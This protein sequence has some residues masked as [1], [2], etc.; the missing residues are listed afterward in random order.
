[1]FQ[2]S[3]KSVILRR[4]S[5]EYIGGAARVSFRFRFL[6]A[7]CDFFRAQAAGTWIGRRFCSRLKE[8]PKLNPE[9]SGLGF[10]GDKA[11]SF[12]PHR[13]PEALFLIRDIPKSFPP[14]SP[15]K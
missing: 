6:T 15:S 14:K 9:R 5:R 8:K 3:S 11:C 4:T 12:R 7:E 10:Y 13:F 2:N 1:M